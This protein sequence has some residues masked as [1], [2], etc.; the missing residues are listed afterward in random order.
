MSL[1]EQLFEELKN[2]MREK[3][4]LR[5]NTVQSIRT[6]VLQVEKDDHVELSDDGVIQI[7]ASQLKK[8]RAALPEYEKSGRED[9]I[10]ELKQEI[11]MLMEYLPQQLSEEEI[12]VIVQ[13]TVEELGITTQKDMGKV[14]S[15]VVAKVSG[16]ADNKLVSQI[17]R[18]VLA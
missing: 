4:T 5:K 14:M 3:N 8:R 12:T 2:A 16:K 15:A 13:Q 11:E 6:A 1:K 10:S 18:K 17:V 9:L 7:I